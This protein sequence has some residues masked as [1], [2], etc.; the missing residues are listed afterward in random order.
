M[1]VVVTT[2]AALGAARRRGAAVAK[3]IRIG[4]AAT[5]VT[6]IVG[7]IELGGIA[8]PDLGSA[9]CPTAVHTKASLTRAR[10]TTRLRTAATVAI[11]VE[12]TATTIAHAVVPKIAATQPAKG[13]LARSVQRAAVVVAAVDQVGVEARVH[14]ARAARRAGTTVCAHA[15][16]TIRASAT[17]TVRT[18][19]TCTA[20]VT[21][22]EAADG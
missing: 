3:T 2:I 11:H 6:E 21:R 8:G 9:R 20:A 5:A 7:V 12:Q 10:H 13:S 16:A 18:H 17:A 22:A 4:R 15:T 14:R 1:R 19:T